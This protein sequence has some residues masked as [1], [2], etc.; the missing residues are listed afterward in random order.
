MVGETSFHHLFVMAEVNISGPL[1]AVFIRYDESNELPARRN[2]P[3]VAVATRQPSRLVER[4]ASHALAAPAPVRGR[5]GR[6]GRLRMFSARS[7]PSVVE[8]AGADAF[9]CARHVSASLESVGLSDF[10]G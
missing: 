8:T 6:N 2:D 5:D 9:A 3:G 1:P 10:A 7:R 4:A